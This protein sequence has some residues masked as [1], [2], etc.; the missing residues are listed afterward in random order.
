LF[1]VTNHAIATAPKSPNTR[2]APE[3]DPVGV[4]VAATNLGA[5]LS[6]AADAAGIVAALGATG[7]LVYIVLGGALAAACAAAARAAATAA[8]VAFTFAINAV[9]LGIAGAPP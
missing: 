7:A 2:S 8:T 6:S 5:G 3:C 1:L 4:V 9:G